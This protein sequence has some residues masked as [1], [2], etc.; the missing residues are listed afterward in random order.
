MQTPGTN[1]RRFTTTL[2]T[3]ESELSRGEQIVICLVVAA[4]LINPLAVVIGAALLWRRQ[5]A[6]IARSA[7]M[8]GYAAA[9]VAVAG[10]V[11]YRSLIGPAILVLG[12]WWNVWAG[13]ATFDPLRIV[14]GSIEQ[15]PLTGLL[16][17]G[18]AAAGGRINQW[19]RPKHEDEPDCWRPA[20]PN[21]EADKRARLAAIRD[22]ALKPPAGH[23][24]LG[25]NQ[26]G[27]PVSFGLDR[28]KTHAWVTGATGTGKT[29][30]IVQTVIAAWAKDHRPL[31]V[32]DCKGSSDLVADLERVA[33]NGG[34][35]FRLWTPNRFVS[36]W[37][38]LE[39]TLDAGRRADLILA[40]QEYSEPHYAAVGRRA[41][42]LYFEALATR[43][44]RP[45][46][47]P[48]GRS[49]IYAGKT[50][51]E[52]PALSQLDVDRITLADVGRSLTVA[53][54]QALANQVDA[55]RDLV[56]DLHA[57]VADPS[58]DVRSGVS[59]LGTRIANIASAAAAGTLDAAPA[60]EAHRFDLVSALSSPGISLLSINEAMSPEN[61]K[62]VAEM[63]LVALQQAIGDREAARAG[64]VEPLQALVV[65]D[66]ASALD[67]AL[68][69]DSML[70]RARSAKVGIC[71]MVQSPSDL[72]PAALTSVMS[73]AGI[74]VHHR[75]T[76]PPG[77]DL[78]L[79]SVGT[80]DYW[81]TTYQTTF[82]D[83]ATGARWGGLSGKGTTKQVTR[84]RI[85]PHDLANLPMGQAFVCVAGENDAETVQRTTIAFAN[86]RRQS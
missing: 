7:K 23:V 1:T 13:I 84:L 53:S 17:W 45:T 59:G 66:E 67:Q 3:R 77:R 57:F 58:A 55:H 78:I 81:E 52:S 47:V 4:I 68:A 35:P 20:L 76:D 16:A 80:R 11:L 26:Y 39:Q 83:R 6:G 48:D 37:N 21:E 12:G 65:I 5:T 63:A 43:S 32:I 9:F 34:V 69:L 10:V 46:L 75:C 64:G 24:L 74:G 30:T 73:N 2:W 41:L 61:A 31:V 14:R 62:A 44:I 51:V 19:L 15:L 70:K 71:V 56:R 36:A 72:P 29:T 8:G 25:V 50:L 86:T 33:D 54:L 79:Q 85:P 40:T 27:R 60:G 42:T 22:N 28:L 49:P 38:P 82:S 18:T